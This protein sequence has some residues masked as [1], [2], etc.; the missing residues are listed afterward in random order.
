MENLKIEKN[1][2]YYKDKLVL[3]GIPDTTT[4]ET[5]NCLDIKFHKVGALIFSEYKGSL[6]LYCP[7]NLKIRKHRVYITL[8]YDEYILL[9]EKYL[10]LSQEQFMIKTHAFRNIDTYLIIIEYLP[11]VNQKDVYIWKKGWRKMR[12]FKGNIASVYDYIGFIEFPDD[13][14]IVLHDG[15]EVLRDRV[16]DSLVIE[17]IDV[18]LYYLRS[19][20]VVFVKNG[21]YV[22]RF[23]RLGKKAHDLLKDMSDYD[24]FKTINIGKYQI[25]TPDILYHREDKRYYLIKYEKDVNK[26]KLK[27]TF[28]NIEINKENKLAIIKSK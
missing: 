15:E 8:G 19:N 17:K 5:K 16:V 14:L 1:K 10:K 25:I 12:P 22:N 6:R 4:I 20:G 2:L 23:N 7:K 21:F 13:E 9:P 24:G 18:I 27:S 11:Q 28:I 26:A 3:K